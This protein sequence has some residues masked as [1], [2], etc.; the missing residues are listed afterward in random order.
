MPVTSLYASILA[1]IFVLLSLNVIRNRWKFKQGILSKGQLPLDLSIRVHANFAEY[2]PL[3]LILMGAIE[4]NS[5]N[6]RWLHIC[7]QVLVAGR[8]LH[9]TGL[10]LKGPGTS[11]PRFIGTAATFTV[12]I[13]LA[14]WNMR[15]VL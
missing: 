2:I 1:I 12:M 9:A 14:I 3:A 4:I 11:A 6:I 5:G 15:L 10:L 7:G 13:G 8:L